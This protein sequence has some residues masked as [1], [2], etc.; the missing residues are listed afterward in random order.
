MP[1]V[2]V[3]EGIEVRVSMRGVRGG[4]RVCMPGVPAIVEDRVSIIYARRARGNNII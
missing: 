4:R 1:G 2:P 3:V